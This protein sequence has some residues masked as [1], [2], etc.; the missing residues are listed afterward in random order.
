MP[1]ESEK[2]EITP[3]AAPLKAEERDK[4]RALLAGVFFFMSLIVALWLFNTGYLFKK[5]EVK[6]TEA[7]DINE[8]SREF[9]QA[10]H[11]VGEKMSDLKEINLADLEE[12]R[13]ESAELFINS[14]STP[15]DFLP[16]IKK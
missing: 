7:F 12:L 16:A 8:F 11:D 2:K 6:K 10:F 1:I 14:S 9:S 13:Q 4:H 3:E 5:T 15:E